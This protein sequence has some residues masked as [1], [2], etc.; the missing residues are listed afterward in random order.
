MSNTRQLIIELGIRKR[1]IE[2]LEARC[3]ELVETCEKLLRIADAVINGSDVYNG[4]TMMATLEARDVIAR[5]K[6]ETA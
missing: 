3:D 4:D 2:A 6:E 5:A 1:R